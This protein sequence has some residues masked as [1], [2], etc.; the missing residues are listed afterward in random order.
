M[1]HR[2]PD[3]NKTPVV[4]GFCA[5]GLAVRRHPASWFGFSRAVSVADVRPVPYMVA[6]ERRT[7]RVREES[8]WTARNGSR[9]LAGT[10]GHEAQRRSTQAIFEDPV[11]PE[12]LEGE[13]RRVG[14]CCPA[15]PRG[16]WRWRAPRC[17]RAG[18]HRGA[19]RHRNRRK[20]R[21]QVQPEQRGRLQDHLARGR[22]GHGAALRPAKDRDA[23]RWEEHRRD[24][25]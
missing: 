12:L 10:D 8:P 2:A 24:P 7:Q 6:G 14:R 15:G 3:R 18:L 13:R 1:I 16:L 20:A 22:S 23:G 21:R 19:G 9:R 5:G 17:D 11:P 4:C 25:G